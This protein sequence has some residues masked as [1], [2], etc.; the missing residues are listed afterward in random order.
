MDPQLIA[1]PAHEVTSLAHEVTSADDMEAATVSAPTQPWSTRTLE[2]KLITDAN[3]QRV[4]AYQAALAAIDA[5]RPK[6]KAIQREELLK[7]YRNGQPLVDEKTGRPITAPEHA[8]TASREAYRAFCLETNRIERL[9]GIKPKSMPDEYCPL[10]V[11][12]H[13]VIKKRQNL[14]SW[15]LPILGIDSQFFP[16]EKGE[17]L[18]DL[19]SKLLLSSPLMLNA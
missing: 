15:N 6:V 18:A 11:A 12:Q 14:L 2:A 19:I 1:I 16:L 17:K 10:L 13:E 9:T 3:L 5:I 4:L 7:R 8:W